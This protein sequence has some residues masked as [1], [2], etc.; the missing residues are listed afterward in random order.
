MG[1]AGEIWI[2]PEADGRIKIKKP[3]RSF[4]L[5]PD[6]DRQTEHIMNQ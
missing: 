4:I 6:T 5:Q 1:E 3:R 2:C